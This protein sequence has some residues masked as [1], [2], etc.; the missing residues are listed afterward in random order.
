MKT[1][2]V[3]YSTDFCDDFPEQIGSIEI[4]AENEQEAEKKFY[5]LKIFKAVL[6][7]IY[8]RTV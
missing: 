1:Y 6:D 7:G 2:D 3:F 4:E 8:E 5:A